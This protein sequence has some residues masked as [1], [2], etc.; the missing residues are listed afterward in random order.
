MI[1]V[2][3]EVEPHNARKG[4][5][6]D[7]AA[8]LNP[9]VDGIDGFISI[10]RFESLSQPGKLVAIS[11]WRDEDAIEEWRNL[12]EHRRAQSA[13]RT[14]LFADYRVRIASILR[15]YSMGERDEAPEDSRK[16]HG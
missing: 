9:L 12:Q 2:I 6:L 8:E 13:G 4:D 15:D 5:Y 14:G 16:A 7:I 10:E 11:Y 3:F 1:A